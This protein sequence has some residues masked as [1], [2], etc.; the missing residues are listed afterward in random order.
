MSFLGVERSMTG[1]RWV[2][3]DAGIDRAAEALVQ[4]C[5]LPHPVALVLARRGVGP[6]TAEAYLKP[7]LRDLLPDPRSLKDMERA[8]ARFLQAVERREQIAIFAD[9]DVDGGSSAALLIWWLR[10]MGL[11]ATLYVPDRID[12]GYGPNPLAMAALARDHDLI[13]CVDCGTLSHDALAAAEGAD[14]VVLDHHLGGETLP[15]ALAVVNPNRQD[16][17]GDLGHLCAAAVVFLMLVEAGRQ[18]R[19]AGKTGPDLMS[20]LDLVALATVA[21]VAPLTGVN[22]ALVRQGLTVMGR[23]HRPGLVA[24][25]DAARLDTAPQAYH[26]GFVLGPRVNAGGRIG[27]ADL[28]ARLLSTADPHEASAMAARLEELN[29]E[30]REIEAQVRLAALDQ[31]EERGLDAPL[32]WAAGEGWHPGVVGIVASRLKETA[33]RPAIVIGFDGDEGKGSGRSVSGVDLGASIQRL[34]QEGLLIKGGGH[35]MA[36]GLTVARD[37]LEPAMARLSELLAKQGAGEAGPADLRL[38]GALM[39]GAAT[40]ELITA[41]EDAGP[42]GA[43]SPAPRFALPEMQ[44][45]FAKRVGETHLKLTISDGMGAGLDAICFGAFESDLG[46]RL[47]AGDGARYHLAG[48]LEINHWGGRQRVQ[49]RVEDAAPA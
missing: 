22:R 10:D 30:R 48:R 45:K 4:G 37:Q 17:S 25:A 21:D 23:R 32:V 5:D 29:A 36:A 26:L 34:A 19:E 38:D 41:L 31:A 8:A 44:I 16:E 15:P 46:P 9:Y 49:M 39:P 42:F 24:L 1:R 7:L 33:N 27:Q 20:L 18:L 11:S 14:V 13:L 40:P 28:G 2:G 47:S 3:P 35:K 43:S 12:E 6:E